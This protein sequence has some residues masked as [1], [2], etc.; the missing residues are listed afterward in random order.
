MLKTDKYEEK[1]TNILGFESNYD[2]IERSATLTHSGLKK[3]V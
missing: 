3:E 2:R 1:L